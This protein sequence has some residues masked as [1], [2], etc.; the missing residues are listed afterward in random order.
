M[1]KQIDRVIGDFVKQVGHF[2]KGAGNPICVGI[3]GINHATTYT[4]YEGKRAW[5]TDG[6]SSYRHPV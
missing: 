4:S 2:R 6:T 3:A 5:P 1:I